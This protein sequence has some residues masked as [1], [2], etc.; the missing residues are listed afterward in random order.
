[1]AVVPYTNSGDTKKEQ[2]AGMFNKISKKY[3][4]LNHLLS[5]NIDKLW[6]KKAI[7]ILSGF[8]PARIIDIATGTADFAIAACKLNPGQITGIDISQGMLDIGRQKVKKK[9]LEGIIELVLADSEELPFGSNCF[10]AAICS[11]GVRNFE[12]L[13]KGLKEAY[14]VLNENGVFVILEFSKPGKAPFKQVYNFYFKKIL[15]AIGRVVSKDSS[16]YSYL[17]DSVDAF[18]S[19]IGF[20]DILKKAGFVEN[21]MVPLTFG[22]ATIYICKKSKT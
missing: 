13:E 6:R 3:D 19:G 15:P 18:P 8:N 1:M 20:I 21:K 5:L 22:I 7:R 2:V 4:F 10:D 9:N 12:T 14:R 16:A 11:F 17:P